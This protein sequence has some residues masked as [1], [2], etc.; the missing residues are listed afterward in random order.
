MFNIEM[1][2]YRQVVI[3]N[4]GGSCQSKDLKSAENAIGRLN[5]DVSSFDHQVI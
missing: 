2:I 5:D 3:S 1:H 4:L